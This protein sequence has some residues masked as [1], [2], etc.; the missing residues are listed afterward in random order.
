VRDSG[1][2]AAMTTLLLALAPDPNSTATF[3]PVQFFSGLGIT[4]FAGVLG[5]SGLIGILTHL[6]G[7][8]EEDASVRTPV[9]R[10]LGAF[11]LFVVGFLVMVTSN[12]PMP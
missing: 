3:S 9:F 5:L 4:L 8:A 7:R 10:V 6:L 2:N 12:I 11:V 1:D